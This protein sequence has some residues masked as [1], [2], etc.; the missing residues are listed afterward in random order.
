ML[1]WF[2]AM[3]ASWLSGTA[4]RLTTVSVETWQMHLAFVIGIVVLTNL[5]FL[6]KS[7]YLVSALPVVYFAFIYFKSR[8]YAAAGVPKT[9]VELGLYLMEI[10]FFSIIVILNYD[11]TDGRAVR[12][13]SKLKPTLQPPTVDLQKRIR[14]SR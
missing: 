10:I 9:P 6:I 5:I 3:F 11:V 7:L 13:S 14:V 2:V 8:A 1:I 4:S 12:L